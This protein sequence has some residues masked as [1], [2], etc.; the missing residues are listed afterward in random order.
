MGGDRT[1]LRKAFPGFSDRALGWLASSLACFTH[2]DWHRVIAWRI[3]QSVQLDKPAADRKYTSTR[4]VACDG[5]CSLL[6]NAGLER[7]VAP[8]R[9]YRTD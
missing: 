2:S 1:D 9:L 5:Q 3:N 4:A 8:A 7:S 6:G